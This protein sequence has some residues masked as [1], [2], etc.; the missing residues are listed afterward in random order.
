MS[1]AFVF[2]AS[3]IMEFTM[4][5]TGASSSDVRE[6][7]RTSVFISERTSSSDSSPFMMDSIAR[8]GLVASRAAFRRARASEICFSGATQDQTC[9]PAA[10]A[11][12]SCAGRLKGS[13]RAIVNRPPSLARGTALTLIQKSSDLPHSKS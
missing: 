12:S 13:A 7:S 3:I 6:A 1:D 9:P 2:N 8:A 5:M 11:T 4:R 10:R